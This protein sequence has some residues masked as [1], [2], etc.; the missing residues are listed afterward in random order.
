MM[1]EAR[2]SPPAAVPVLLVIHPDALTRHKVKLTL[3]AGH[4][5]HALCVDSADE[6]LHLLADG[7]SGLAAIL[8]P[9][10]L[11]AEGA[12]RFLDGLNIL[13]PKPRPAVIIVGGGQS[14]HELHDLND[15]GAT[16]IID[17]PVRLE[18]VARELV[19]L[20]QTGRS[21]GRTRLV[22][23]A[24]ARPQGEPA[25]IS[26]DPNW[27]D[28][29]VHLAATTR[30][31]SSDFRRNR[32]V[33]LLGRLDELAG[34]RLSMAYVEVL[35][36]MARNDAR[37]VE[38]LIRAENL[39]RDTIDRLFAV[40]E[41]RMQF[42]GGQP[43]PRAVIVHA[44]E[45]LLEIARLRRRGDGWTANYSDLKAGATDVLLGRL[46][47]ESPAAKGYRDRLCAWLGIDPEMLGLVDN[48]RLRRIASRVVKE[49][50]EQN[51][52]DFARLSLL[53]HLLKIKRIVMAGQGLE[54]YLRS[55]G[56]LLG[57]AASTADLRE[58]ARALAEGHEIHPD[59]VPM[60]A[61]FGSLFSVIEGGASAAGFDE[62]SLDTLRAAVATAAGVTPPAP[63]RPLPTSTGPSASAHAPAPAASAGTPAAAAPPP[64]APRSETNAARLLPRLAADLGLADGFFSHLHAQ[65]S[66]LLAQLDRGPLLDI[67]LPPAVLARL[68][69][70]AVLLVTE[71][72]DRRGLLQ[73]AVV[74]H[75]DHQPEALDALLQ[76]ISRSGAP[77]VTAAFRKSLGLLPRPSPPREVQQILEA[78]DPL[79]TWLALRDLRDD[80][81]ESIP[82]LE[83]AL[84]QLERAA[85]S[86]VGF[87]AVR[88]AVERRLARLRMHHT[89]R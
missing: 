51:A 16:S 48:D 78:E 44:I 83:S 18:D 88:Q 9:W 19:A 10:D 73:A 25:R 76:V 55:M 80:D 66:R 74:S 57:D 34:G 32:L 46:S 68:R 38:S 26:K 6:A 36:L 11:P 77:E 59:D 12:F 5:A 23:G 15:V 2:P 70:L 54:A 20:R 7:I 75:Y 8:V 56:G 28:R 67:Q 86:S 41:E 21:P 29:M 39:N 69:V 49:P 14:P 64:A 43:A 30:S 40:V 24:V 84:A 81:P 35:L 13:A 62:A 58:K 45:E 71:N 31:R 79:L 82:I 63:G 4:H 3:S 87:E 85:V 1:S 61:E 65:E 37:Q 52:M 50:D 33:A 22:T 72:V 60:F 47:L 89:R 27:R 42:P 17:A 53:A